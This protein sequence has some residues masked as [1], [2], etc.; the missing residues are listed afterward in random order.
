[1]GAFATIHSQTRDPLLRR[2]RGINRGRKKIGRNLR[3]NA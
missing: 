2:V 1:M 3:A